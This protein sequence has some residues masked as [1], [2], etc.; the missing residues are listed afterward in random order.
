MKQIRTPKGILEWVTIDG[1][2]KENLSGK[3]Q[4]VANLVL[5]PSKP[6]DEAFLDSIN[7]F[8]EQNK[9]KTFT[10]NPKSNGIYPHKALTSDTDENGKAIYREDGR[11][12]VAFKTS[13]TWSNGDPKVIK[14][15]NAKGKE[16]SLGGIKI[17]NGSIGRIGGAMAIYTN[18]TKQGA[19]VDAGVTLYL[20]SIQLIKLVEYAAEAD[21]D[22]ESGDADDTWTGDSEWSGEEA[23]V[24]RL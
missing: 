15:Y 5:N 11:V 19:I 20:N 14:T 18:S 10:R 9:P 1:E 16:A 7:E 3:M 2:G 17:G 4:Y 21:Y 23:A 6:E 8:W 22:D 12:S 24:N 13:T